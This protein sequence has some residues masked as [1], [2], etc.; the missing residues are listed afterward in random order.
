MCPLGYDADRV[1]VRSDVEVRAMGTIGLL[2][3]GKQFDCDGG[4]RSQR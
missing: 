1:A 3:S 2:E 4:E